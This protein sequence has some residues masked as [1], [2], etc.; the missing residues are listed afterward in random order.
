MGLAQTL[1][2]II[3]GSTL[4]YKDLRNSFGYSLH[5]WKF[6]LYCVS[7]WLLAYVH[8][9]QITGAQQKRVIPYRASR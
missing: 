5:L 4:H 7:V 1:R 9:K 8:E 6:F 2:R 3:R